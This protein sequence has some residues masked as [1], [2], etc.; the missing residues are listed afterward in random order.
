MYMNCKIFL[1]SPPG[2][3]AY[4]VSIVSLSVRERRSTAVSSMVS[5]IAR[6]VGTTR[7]RK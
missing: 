4:P 1:I 3:F 5:P 6:G 2:V 7:I